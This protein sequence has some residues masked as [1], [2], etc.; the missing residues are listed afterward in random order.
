MPDSDSN[1]VPMPKSMFETQPCES[2][3]ETRW[4]A[5]MICDADPGHRHWACSPCATLLS[6]RF[7]SKAV[8]FMSRRCPPV[9]T[10]EERDAY[11]TLN[12]LRSLPAPEEGPRA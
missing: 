3:E 4:C 11:D 12:A 5:P 8:A 10:D 1:V 7:D 2:C 9:V 6:V